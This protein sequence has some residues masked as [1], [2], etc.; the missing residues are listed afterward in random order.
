MSGLR[1]GITISGSDVPGR[2]V[3]VVLGGAR[4]S[5]VLGS[6]GVVVVVGRVWCDVE[7]LGG[8]VIVGL[9]VVVVVVGVA[10]VVF[11]G[12]IVVVVTVGADVGAVVVV[13]VELVTRVEV[14]AGLGSG[15]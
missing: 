8:T 10:V 9:A 7:A 15:L 4:G 12:T 3:D 1:L 13:V 5:I 6:Q 11:L 14:G 2:T